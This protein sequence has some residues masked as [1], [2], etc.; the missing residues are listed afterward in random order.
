MSQP[1]TPVSGFREGFFQ[2][3]QFPLL[4]GGGRST[5][6][7]LVSGCSLNKFSPAVFIARFKSSRTPEPLGLHN[8]DL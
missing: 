3:S 5:T 6:A 8:V 4:R 7:R 1:P 2:G